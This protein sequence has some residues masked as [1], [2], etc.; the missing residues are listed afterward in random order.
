MRFAASL[1]IFCCLAGT[2]SASELA[3]SPGSGSVANGS[4][5]DVIVQLSSEEPITAAEASL[6]FD[7]Q[8]FEVV[9]IDTA[10]SLIVGWPT[11]PVFSNDR[12]I[13]T[14]SGSMD[15]AWSGAEGRILVIRF[16]AKGNGSHEVRFEDGVA[17]SSAGSNTITTL[18]SGVYRV[19]PSARAPE[20][21][22]ADLAIEEPLPAESTPVPIIEK[23]ATELQPGDRLVV[24]GLV[25]PNVLV[26]ISVETGGVTSVYTVP[27]AGDGSF[28]YVSDFRVGE[29][30]YR[31][32]AAAEGKT[33][34]ESSMPT[35]Y[36]VRP[37]GL[38]AAA[39]M[40]V[41]VMTY[42][43]PILALTA[44]LGLIAAYIL[45]RRRT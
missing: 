24:R 33:K 25:V 5:F 7:P 11:Q 36:T 45:N 37:L 27:S 13:I 39:G 3:L 22:D 28:V 32:T 44:L 17:L 40:A 34:G 19:E 8:A 43:I 29:G 35:T 12:G 4:A 15:S 21:S 23:G 31:V 20:E 41:E 38:A 1:A 10:S 26:H 9:S 30:V 18:T 42:A 6:A 14:F 2:A 16:R